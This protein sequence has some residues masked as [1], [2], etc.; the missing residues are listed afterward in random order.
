M[1]IRQIII[2]LIISALLGLLVN[3]ISPNGIELIGK[4]RDIS[5]GNEPIIPPNAEEGDPAFIALSLAELEFN[6]GEV[7]FIDCREF[8]EFKCGTIPG[9]IN[10]PF[11]YLPDENLELYID[12]ALGSVTKDNKIITFCSGDECDQSLHLARNLQAFG[13]KNVFI[14]FGGS[15][16]WE[17][18]GLELEGRQDCGK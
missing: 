13:Y 9:S 1:I 12:S 17:N 14:F 3:T 5:S 10:I 4:Y 6:L 16:E 7:L 2:L 15:R 18:Y 11:D 8:E